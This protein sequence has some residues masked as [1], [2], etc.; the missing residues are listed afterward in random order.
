MGGEERERRE[1][2]AV[3]AE[4]ERVLCAIGGTQSARTQPRN[5]LSLPITS[6]SKLWY[7]IVPFSSKSQSRVTRGGPSLGREW[8]DARTLARLQNRN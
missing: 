4:A 3:A 5:R 8:D 7:P 2:R 6:Q 1:T